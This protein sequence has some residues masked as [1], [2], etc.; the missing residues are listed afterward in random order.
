MSNRLSDDQC[1]ALAAWCHWHLG[2]GGF[3]TAIAAVLEYPAEARKALTEDGLPVED[4]DR[5]FERAFRTR[6]EA[7]ASRG[8]R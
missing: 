7:L 1:Q 3:A 6:F 8:I 5:A 4:I 2:G